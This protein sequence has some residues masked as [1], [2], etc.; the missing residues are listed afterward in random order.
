M[1]LCINQEDQAAMR[2]IKSPEEREQWCEYWRAARANVGSG[3]QVR[4]LLGYPV[5]DKQ[6]RPT[7]GQQFCTAMWRGDKPRE[8]E[9]QKMLKALAGPYGR[10][11]AIMLYQSKNQKLPHCLRKLLQQT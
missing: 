3:R 11:A 7:G 8:P 5:I 2:K 10:I 4:Y 6:G 9:R 1:Q